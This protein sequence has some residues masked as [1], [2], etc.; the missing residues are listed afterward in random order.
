VYKD[1]AH[2]AFE[3]ARI[4]HWDA[5]ASRLDKWA[6]WSQGYHRRLAD[7]YS[8]LI[9]PGLRVLEIGCGTGDLLA[10]LRPAY[11]VGVDFSGGMLD[12]ARERHRHLNFVHCAADE[13]EAGETFDFI[14]CSDF[15]NDLWDVQ[16]VLERHRSAAHP[17]TR[18]MMNFYSR[19]WEAPLRAAKAL[20]ISRPLL[21]QNWLTVRDVT[22]L[23]ALS[24]YEVVRH[25]EEILWPVPTPIIEPLCNRVL[26]KLWP[27]SSL[28]LTHMVVARP[29][30]AI[31]G[32]R[33]PLVSVIVPAR[34]EAGNIAQIF[35]RV[36]DMG[37]GTELIFVEGHSGDGTLETIRNAI[38]AHPERRGAVYQQTGTGKGDAVRLG[39]ARSNGDVLMI[40][41]ADLTVRPEDLPR[42]YDALT[43]GVGEFI[44]GVRLVYPMQDKAMRFFNFLGNKFFSALFSWLLGQPIKDTLCGTKVLWRR[45]Y[46]LIAAGRAGVGEYDPFGDFDLL[47]GAAALS[48]KIVEMPVRYRERIYG[49]TNIRRWSDGWL[50]LKMAAVAARRL[51]WV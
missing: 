21:D 5:V 4:R 16:G 2:R 26:V 30:P 13:F 39:F 51:K 18:L 32:D 46:Y 7:I 34:N 37:A 8:A 17:G 27:L 10:A 25:W 38:A 31:E 41:D 6:V 42:F 23:L 14:V 15:V 19:L 22:N 24:S 9:P 11:G 43:S 45:D 12:I 50:L 47:F 49:E 29:A 28:A 20:G 35:E 48:R 44:N 40:L 3:Q 33:K 36:P 1:E